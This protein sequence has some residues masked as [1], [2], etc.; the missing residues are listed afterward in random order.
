[1][2]ARR[3]VHQRPRQSKMEVAIGSVKAHMIVAPKVA[4]RVC[5]RNIS[6]RKD[7]KLLEGLKGLTSQSQTLGIGI[8]SKS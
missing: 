7:K 3:R 5:G 2:E 4:P 1:M 6:L 8:R